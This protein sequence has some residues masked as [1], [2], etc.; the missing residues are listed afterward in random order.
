MARRKKKLFIHNYERKLRIE[1]MMIARGFVLPDGSP[2][3]YHLAKRMDKNLS[4]VIRAFR[5]EKKCN[6]ETS[7]TMIR[8]IAEALEVSASYLIDK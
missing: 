5:S 2:S 3:W 4:S 6:R 1:T 7:L 8:S